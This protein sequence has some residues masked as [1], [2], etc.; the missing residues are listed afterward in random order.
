MPGSGAVVE[1]LASQVDALQAPLEKAMTFGEKLKDLGKGL[2]GFIKEI[3]TGVGQAIKGVLQGL[4]Q[5]LV[6]LAT[7][8]VALTP[9]IPVI[10]AIGAALWMAA[11][12]FE[13][14]APVLVKVAEVIG[15]VLVKALEV[16][17]PIIEKIFNGI[18]Y[19]IEKIGNA[20]SGIINT[21]TD[22]ISK[23]SGLD[24]L[25]ML[26]V[27]GGIAAMAGAVAI[28]GGASGFAGFMSGIGDFFGG[29]PVEK[30]RKFQELDANALNLVAG[31]ITA[32]AT[33]MA[34]FSGDASAN[35]ADSLENL[36]S[37]L[38]DSFNSD[39]VD[40]LGGFSDKFASILP[41]IVELTAITPAI[42]ETAMALHRLADSFKDLA[43]VDV[44]AINNLPWLKLISFAAAGGN[45]QLA[46]SANKSF[47]LTQ[48]TAKNI[49][50]MNTTNTA[51]LQVNKNLQSLLDATLT[52][53]GEGGN[54]SLMIDGKQV[55]K[56][57]K[58]RTDN[59]QGQTPE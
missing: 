29:D 2:G 37:S 54:I 4:G 16:A 33:S 52:N 22:S 5:G 17:G 56:V 32:L 36:G 27:A 38:S 43:G 42:D 34:T 1:G 35:V 3:G 51:M 10:L 21:I 14:I 44:K 20:I 45:I 30:F 11:P 39:L 55:T 59:N 26:A 24:P 41:Q 23:L 19:V 15:N 31:S 28:F 40:T 7:G 46:Q 57:I 48:D 50:Q 13:A 25:R 18:G 49:A 12:A 8:I 58:R 47:N 6:S 9:G 53:N